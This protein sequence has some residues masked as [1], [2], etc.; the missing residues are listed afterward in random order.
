MDFDEVTWLTFVTSNIGELSDEDQQEAQAVYGLMFDA[1]T[2]RQISEAMDAAN[3]LVQGSGVEQIYEFEGRITNS[4]WDADVLAQYVNVEDANT[5]TL[6]FTRTTPEPEFRLQSEGSFVETWRGNAAEAQRTHATDHVQIDR[7]E[8]GRFFANQWRVDPPAIQRLYEELHRAEGEREARAVLRR[9]SD[10]ANQ[11]GVEYVAPELNAGGRALVYINTGDTYNETIGFDVRADAFILTTWGG[12]LEEAE[13]QI[14]EEGEPARADEDV[15]GTCGRIF[16]REE[17]TYVGPDEATCRDCLR[18]EVV[19][20]KPRDDQPLITILRSVDGLAVAVHLYTWDQDGQT[21]H[22][23]FSVMQTEDHLIAMNPSPGR[24]RNRSPYNEWAPP[25]RTWSSVFDAFTQK[26]MTDLYVASSDSKNLNVGIER[27][28][29]SRLSVAMDAF[30][31]TGGKFQP[32]KEFLKVPPV[33]W[34][35]DQVNEIGWITSQPN[36]RG[37]RE[38]VQAFV[39]LHHEPGEQIEADDLVVWEAG[40]EELNGLIEDGFIKFGDDR[41]VREYLQHIGVCRR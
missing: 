41:T 31:E 40:T 26:K 9:I 29:F 3:E 37:D 34:T 24:W 27:E 14:N 28:M 35:C 15:C 25:N 20:W 10:A 19:T 21:P 22:L 12:W 39:R 4:P 33:L 18:D 5:E 32:V 16:N 6:L 23:A 1:R 7:G 17:L 11:F 13:R 30:L 8:F 36:G 38:G 2:V